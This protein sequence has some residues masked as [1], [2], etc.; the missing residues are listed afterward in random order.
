MQSVSSG[1]AQLAT[2]A[3]PSFPQQSA[4]VK[5]TWR[6]RALRPHPLSSTLETGLRVNVIRASV[7]CV[8][9]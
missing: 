5:S 4:H 8:K 9:I 7:D 1:G 6:Q 2:I 3:H